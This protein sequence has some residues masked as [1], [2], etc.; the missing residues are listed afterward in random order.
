MTK[1][2]HPKK[3]IRAAV[4]YALSQKWRLKMAGKSS[5]SWGTLYCP[6][7]DRIG[8]KIFVYRTPR[9]SDNHANQIIKSVDKC[10]HIKKDEK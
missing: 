10:E 5:H 4:N 6:I 1:D 2:K 3:E 7:K 8:C 9:S